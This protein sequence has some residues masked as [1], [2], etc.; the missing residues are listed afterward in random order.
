V[1]RIVVIGCAYIPTICDKA[2][3]QR[4]ELSKLLGTLGIMDQIVAC[5]SPKD[6]PALEELRYRFGK[7]F[8]HQNGY[9]NGH[10]CA[11]WLLFWSKLEYFI[12]NYSDGYYNGH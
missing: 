2:C 9:Y 10:Y 11:I 8:P 4:K 6:L 1:G 12:E 3:P 7:A 5:N